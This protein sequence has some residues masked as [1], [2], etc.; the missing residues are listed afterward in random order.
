MIFLF[1]PHCHI[2]S[3]ICDEPKWLSNVRHVIVL[4]T[5]RSNEFGATQTSMVLN[6][7]FSYFPVIVNNF[8]NKCSPL[9]F[10]QTRRVRG[11]HFYHHL[12][13]HSSCVRCSSVLLPIIPRV[14]IAKKKQSVVICKRLLRFDSLHFDLSN[15]ERLRVLVV[16]VINRGVYPGDCTQILASMRGYAAHRKGAC[17]IGPFRN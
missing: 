13:R 1:A 4:C 17:V 16:V 5:L 8:E 15:R 9:C 11:Y 10:W 12:H 14:E 6:I 2:I 7:F 3:D